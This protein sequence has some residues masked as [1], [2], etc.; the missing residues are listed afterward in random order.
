MNIMWCLFALPESLDVSKRA[1]EGAWRRARPNRAEMGIGGDG[2][3]GMW[4][5]PLPKEQELDGER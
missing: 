3:A 5:P 4:R 2:L 1:E